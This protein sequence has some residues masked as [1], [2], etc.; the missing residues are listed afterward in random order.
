MLSPNF[1]YSAGRARPTPFTLGGHLRVNTTASRNLSA[2]L[3]YEL[4]H[5]AALRSVETQN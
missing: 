5:L 1:Q 3:S 4:R 2:M